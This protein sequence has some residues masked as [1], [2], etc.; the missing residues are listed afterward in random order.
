MFPWRPTPTMNAMAAHVL[1][2]KN[3]LRGASRP[4]DS[5]PVSE[6]VINESVHIPPWVTDHAS[7]RR[8]AG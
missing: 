8:W 4:T 7:F 2:S 1:K 3:N 6:I 5:A